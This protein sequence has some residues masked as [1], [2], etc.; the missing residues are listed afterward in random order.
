MKKLQRNIRVLVVEPSKEP[1]EVTIKN[2]LSE[3]QKLVGGY[4]EYTYLEDNYDVA[5][6]CNEEGKLDGLP[7]NRYIG[8]DII[9]GTFI[10]VGDDDSGEDR[11]LTDEQVERMKLR[12]DKE[13]IKETN[14]EIMRLMLK[15][16][17]EM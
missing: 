12:F 13:S 5:L 6:I 7:W 17:Y 4:I 1:Y 8:H 15:N 9:A 10:V 11:S 16:N 14:T 2:T 3:K